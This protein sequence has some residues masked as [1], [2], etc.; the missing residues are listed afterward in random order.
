MVI[1]LET[2]YIGSD[3]GGFE[4]K[5]ALINFLD[6]NGYKVVDLGPFEYDK[7]DDYPDY[8]EKVCKEVVEKKGLGIL[9]CKYSHGV[10]IAAN[11]VKGIYA[12]SCSNEESA[13]MAKNDSCMNVLCLSGMLTSLK[14]AQTIVGTWLSVPFS[15]EERHKRRIAKIKDMEKK[16][17]K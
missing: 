1:S 2:I 6:K 17:F 10:T 3:H 8:V 4:L 11:K 14:D 7:D 15:G 5:N 13:R 12:S 9:I 16:N